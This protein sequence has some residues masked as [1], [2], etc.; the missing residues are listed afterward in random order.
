M[1]T[2]PQA[3]AGLTPLPQFTPNKSGRGCRGQLGGVRAPKMLLG[4]HMGRRCALHGQIETTAS[5]GA[6]GSWRNTLL[7]GKILK[8][9]QARPPAPQQR[10]GCN[11]QS[12]GL[13]R[14]DEST[15]DARDRLGPRRH[16]QEP[17]G[18]AGGNTPPPKGPSRLLGTRTSV[19]TPPTCTRSNSKK[20]RSN[21][22]PLPGTPTSFHPART[23]PCPAGS[24]LRGCA[25]EQR[26]G[27]TSVSSEWLV[28][29]ALYLSPRDLQRGGLF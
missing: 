5:P 21:Q 23:G 26:V 9:G 7:P 13:E 3:G 19:H 17:G 12:C 27:H 18:P 20:M 25:P 29:T 15:E 6:H 8:S 10:T 2:A 14:R 1:L 28:A 22:L 24:D 16:G 11:T 4:P